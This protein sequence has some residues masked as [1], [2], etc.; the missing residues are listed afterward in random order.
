MI[1]SI[2]IILYE[3]VFGAYVCYNFVVLLYSFC[4]A[5]TIGADP[6][7][8]ENNGITPLMWACIE[9]HKEVS[10]LLLEHGE[11]LYILLKCLECSFLS[12]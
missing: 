10:G 2:V 9:G 4:T 8:K 11:P 1:R 3:S 7:A 6:Q 5:F 12:G